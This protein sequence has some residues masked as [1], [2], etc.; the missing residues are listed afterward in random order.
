MKD[1][2]AKTA[3]AQVDSS[4]VQPQMKEADDAAKQ[5]NWVRAAACLKDAVTI[6]PNLSIVHR[7][8]A[9]ALNKLGDSKE[10]QRE[11]KRAD[12]LDKEK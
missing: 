6:A 9:E 12:D 8:L 5:N 7:K 1:P 11:T 3:L 10:A 2:E 4:R